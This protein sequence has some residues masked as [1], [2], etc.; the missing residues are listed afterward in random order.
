MEKNRTIF[1]RWYGPALLAGFL[2]TLTFPTFNIFPLAWVALVPLLLFLYDSDRKTSFKAGFLFGVIYFFG[3]TYWIY[4][5][6]NKYGNFSFIPSLFIVLLLC[7]YLSLYPALFSYLYSSFIKRMDI[8]S[9]FLAPVLWTTL[10]FFRSYAL[11]GFPW[12]SL[13]YSQYLFQPLIQIADITGVYGVSFLIVAVNGALTDALLMKRKHKERPLASFLPTYSGL[14]LLAL[15]LVM[16]FVYGFYRLYQHREGHAVKVAVIQGNIEQ[17]K[18]WDPSY[19]QSVLST[20]RDIS[21]A[22]AQEAPHLIVWPETSAPFLFG[23]DKELTSQLLSFEQQLN[24]YLLFGSVLLRNT[25]TVK[26]YTN[27]AVLLDKNGNIT[28]IYDKIHLVPFGE[29]VPLKP[30]LFFVNTLGAGI[31]DYVPGN[32][33]IK[34]VTPFGSFGTLICYEIIFP[35]LVRKFFVRGG[36]FM[37]TITNDAWFGTT[38]GPYQHFSMAVFRAI[39]NRKPVVRAANTGISGF[40]DS[41]GRIIGKTELF[42]RTYMVKEI[43]TDATVSPY[44]KYGDIF[45]YLNIVCFLLLLV[46]KRK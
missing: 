5:S 13:G 14:I 40:I 21:F 4:H 42:R 36:D 33:Y 2:L 28:Y 25:E 17:D 19:Q 45:S 37:V 11:S 30:L 9:L 18:K 35:G 29:Y 43:R 34:A 23:D 8:P 41:N 20:F 16:S 22:A 44:T 3:T 10:E 26:G 39:E 7:L 27:S 31:G 38:Q 24:S 1:Y 46:G 32:S 12:S 6:I 15:T